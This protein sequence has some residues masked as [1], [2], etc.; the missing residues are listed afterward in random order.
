MKA[1]L[2]ELRWRGM[3]NDCTPNLQESIINGT[4]H[5]A[6]V[7]FDPTAP[8]LTIG[9]LVSLMLLVHWQ[10]AGGK[11][12]VLLGG[13]TGRIGD[14]SFK[15]EERQLMAYDLLDKNL[16]HQAH[17]FHHYLDFE[18]E[19]AAI[20]V[21]NHDIYKDMSALDFLRDIGKRITVSYMLAKDSVKTRLKTGLSFT[22]FSYQLIQG[23]DYQ[24]LLEHHNCT[25]QMGGSDQWGNIMTGVEI[26]RRNLSK[27]VHALTTP[28]LT[29][30]DGTKYGKTEAGNIW[31]DPT[32]TSPYQFYQFCLN[33]TDEDMPKLLRIFLLKTQAEIE[34]I[35]AEHALAP[36][37]RVAQRALA[38]ELT[39]RVHSPEA[40]ASA[41]KVS[42]L[43]FSKDEA[44]LL[45]LSANDW[46]MV[47]TEIPHFAVSDLDE[48]VSV[49]ELLSVKTTCMDSNSAVRRAV[50][51]GALSI[52]R[53]KITAHDQIITGDNWLFDRYLLVENG[54]KNKF[55][56][57][58]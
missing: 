11:A 19:N 47:A 32:L 55:V 35:E 38:N 57:Q 28:L 20:I 24:Y 49:T 2:D 48:T 7:G 13:A 22:E 21:N 39:A 4:T 5:T 27:S 6:Y 12:I 9:N 14:P 8:S 54:K 56:I 26:V 17:Q 16:A 33:S 3:L 43:L 41:L 37:L 36:H 52:N 34:A 15:A 40:L 53:K 45:S 51:E 1:F 23:Y 10:R 44:V 30:A 50:K 58:K 25:L 29:K 31:L 46:A 42:E 18:G